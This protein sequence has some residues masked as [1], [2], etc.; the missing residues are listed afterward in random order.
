MTTTELPYHDIPLPR[1]PLTGS[2]G[3]RTRGVMRTRDLYMSRSAMEAA[4]GTP[5]ARQ[6]IAEAPTLSPVTSSPST[7]MVG[8]LK[9]LKSAGVDSAMRSHSDQENCCPDDLMASLRLSRACNTF[10]QPSK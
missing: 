6:D 10:G 7:K 9:R 4:D 8:E 5:P 1:C 2:D 3:P